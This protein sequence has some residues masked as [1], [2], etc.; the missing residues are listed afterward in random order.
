MGSEF[1][2][3]II[4]FFRKSKK[5]KLNL[6]LLALIFQGLFTGNTQTSTN[7]TTVKLKP[8]LEMMA[9]IE[10]KVV[11]I[12]EG[13][14]YKDKYPV[15]EVQDRFDL[16]EKTIRLRFKANI[17]FLWLIK[18]A[19]SDSVIAG[20]I[21]TRGCPTI[22]FCIPKMMEMY[23]GEKVNA[24]DVEQSFSSLIVVSL[25]H[26]LDHL[27]SE[28]MIDGEPKP[29]PFE[30]RIASEIIAW[31]KTCRYTI[32]PLSQ[33]EVSLAKDDKFIYEV[34]VRSGKNATNSVWTGFIRSQYEK[35]R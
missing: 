3:N 34:W 5:M 2:Y 22:A 26:E 18:H 11:P 35:T 8:T 29:V 1:V 16:I 33:H 30:E 17:K 7:S 15:K 20:A 23:E 12:L 14:F 32:G 31:D 24:T 6:I 19:G 21:P 4:K 10:K 25:M 13:Q 9:F 27:E 28:L